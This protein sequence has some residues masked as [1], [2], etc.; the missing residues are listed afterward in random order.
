MYMDKG[1]DTG[2]MLFT[3]EM[4]LDPRETA[5]TLHDRMMHDGADAL[6][7]VLPAIISGNVV[8]EKQDDAVATYAPMLTK[9]LGEL[10]FAKSAKE[11]DALVR[12]L[13]P[14]PIAYTYYQDQTMKVWDAKVVEEEADV[15]VGTIVAVS[16]A[17][18][19]VQTGKGQL[20]ITEVQMP[21]KKRMAVS[22]YI[23]GNSVIQG[24][25]LGR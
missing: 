7:E 22:E 25:F 15:P 2:D 14:W 8:R 6:K 13:N 21:N 11:L 10:D 23:K 18:I 17:G 4:H 1:M 9:A 16:Q 20:C 3:R 5:G 12:G 19:L 24:Q